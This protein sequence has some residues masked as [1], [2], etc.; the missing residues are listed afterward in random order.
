[1]K[2]N[3]IF[4]SAIDCWAF[5]V[6]QFAKVVAGKTGMKRAALERVLWGEF[7]FNP[8]TKSVTRKPQGRIIKPMFVQLILDNIWQVYAEVL[9][10]QNA[11]MV[12]KIIQSLSLKIPARDLNSSD[13][14]V[15]LQA[16]FSR[17]LP[18]S[19]VLIHVWLSPL[20][21]YSM[22]LTCCVAQAVLSVVVDH[23]PSPKQAQSARL[24]KFWPGSALAGAS[25]GKDAVPSHAQNAAVA[26][27]RDRAVA[28]ADAA[29]TCSADLKAD[30]LIYVAKMIDVGTSKT[31]AVQEGKRC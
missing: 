12:Q 31:S 3:V 2:G 17:W 19:T 30:V 15:K 5:T 8:K 28:L 18:I 1:V 21:C 24:P 25:D 27:E 4:A 29:S 10:N 20:D 13:W 6:P 7:Y 14:R 11:A 9:E 23:L 22:I 26:A 16:I